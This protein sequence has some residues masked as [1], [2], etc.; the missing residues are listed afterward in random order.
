MKPIGY[1]TTS[2]QAQDLVS[3]FGEHKLQELPDIDKASLVL[4]LSGLV[5]ANTA[6]IPITPSTAAKDF[7]PVAYNLTTDKI[8]EALEIIDNIKPDEAIGII[9]FLLQ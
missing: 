2:R 4:A 6:E 9:Q 3:K 5:M 1:F 7:I 8:Q